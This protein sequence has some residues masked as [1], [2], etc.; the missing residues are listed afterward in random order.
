MKSLL[1]TLEYPPQKG[2]VAK[3]LESEVQN[4]QKHVDVVNVKRF[5]WRLWP[6]WLPLLFHIKKLFKYGDYDYLWVSHILPLGYIPL[7]LGLKY[8]LYLHGLDLVLPTKSNWKKFWAKK[9]INNAREVFVN[10][11]AT[12]KLLKKYDIDPK[13]AIVRYP[14]IEAVETERY[15]DYAKILRDKHKIGNKLILLTI[16]R[17]VRRK[18]I[19]LVLGALSEIKTKLPDL[20]YVVVGD[21]IEKNNLLKQSKNISNVIFTGNID[22]HEKYGWLKASNCFIL[23]PRDDSNDFEG[24]GIVYKEAQMFGKKVIG[25]N[26]GGVGEAIGEYGLI[27]E[28][29]NIE[30]ISRAVINIL[31]EQNQKA[32]KK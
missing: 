17:L 6:K 15:S 12:A 3:Y 2:G 27:I 1:L 16:A 10:S 8:R 11:K 20:V 5:F 4:S 32:K 18:G 13:T 31:N 25:T 30:A 22:D 24:Y 7:F 14:K 19:D 23:T 9:V 28:P 29:D 21:G 26:V